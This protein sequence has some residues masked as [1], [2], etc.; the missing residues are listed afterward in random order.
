MKN[1][2]QCNDGANYST[3]TNLDD[4]LESN[5]TCAPLSDLGAR[6]HIESNEDISLNKLFKF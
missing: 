4:T 1:V 3:Q 2:M 6:E 5:T